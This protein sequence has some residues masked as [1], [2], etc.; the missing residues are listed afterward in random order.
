[1]CTV[2]YRQLEVSRSTRGSLVSGPRGGLS[3]DVQLSPY[4]DTASLPAVVDTMRTT[5]PVNPFG[6]LPSDST[7]LGSVLEFSLLS[8]GAVVGGPRQ[9]VQLPNV[10]AGSDSLP[11]HFR[12]P[13]GTCPCLACVVYCTTIP[14]PLCR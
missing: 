13:V 10:T 7:A 2:V 6:A 14:T 9:P 8:S 5:W 12:I 3:S 11:V 1:M 4:L